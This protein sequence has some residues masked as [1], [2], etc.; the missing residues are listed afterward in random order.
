MQ[1]RRRARFSTLASVTAVFIL[2]AVFCASWAAA[3]STAGATSGTTTPAGKQL[4]GL[5]G[6]D[7]ASGDAFGVSLALSGSTAIVGAPG[8]A[9]DVG[10]VYVFTQALGGGWKQTAELKGSGTASGD[11]FGYSVAISGDTALIGAPGYAKNVGRAF[12]FTGTKGAWK[13]TAELKGSDSVGND[14]FGV[15]VGVSG[16]GAVV[17][18]DGHSTRAGRAYVFSGASGTW[19]QV[20]ELKGSDVVAKDG[21]GYTVAISGTTAVAGAPDHAKN[22]GRAYVFSGAGG[23][24]KQVAELKG[25]DT[26]ANNGFGVAVAISGTTVIAGAP[27]YAKAAGRAYVFDGSGAAWRQ[28]AELKGSDTVGSN[29]LG[30]A[31]GI[32]GT[33][34]VAGAPG[35]AKDAGRGYLFSKTGADWRQTA[36]LKG[37]GAAGD[38]FGY[39]VAVSGSAALAGADGHAKNAGRAY[40]F[41]A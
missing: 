19:K 1:I 37:S 8:Y 36:V 23:A 20:A 4:T 41:A 12:V 26:V 34:A 39:S 9:K 15:S 25:S 31:V 2:G 14:Y 29:D 22:E 30:Y 24:W 3:A 18:A 28:A 17:G 11:F 10:R 32:S 27:G 21:F 35:Y 7:T 33:T 40:L 16:T 6:S 38:Y 5:V 13:Q